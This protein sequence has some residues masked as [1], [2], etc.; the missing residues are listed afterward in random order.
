M[1]L[2]KTSTPEVYCMPF[3]SRKPT[4]IPGYD[5]S[6]DNYY[7]VTICTHEKSCIFGTTEKLS[8]LGTIAHEDMGKING[9]FSDIIIDNYIIM[10]NHIHAIVI[11]GCKPGEKS[12]TKLEHAIGLYKSG[13][14]RKIHKIYPDLMIWQRSFHDRIIRNQR[15]YEKIWNYVKFNRQKWEADCFHPRN[16]PM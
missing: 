11:V 10:P 15:E 2:P 5:Y 8:V 3:Y 9:H 16:N 12:K 6:T 13:V 7:F 1:T 4:R 14:S